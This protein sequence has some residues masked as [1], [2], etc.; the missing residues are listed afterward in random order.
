MAQPKTL[1]K[2]SPKLYP[3]VTIRSLVA[4][5]MLANEIDAN[6][7]KIIKQD[8]MVSWKYLLKQWMEMKV[9]GCNNGNLENASSGGIIQDHLVSWVRGF[10]HE[11]WI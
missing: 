11:H 6:N 10:C 8:N 7:L 3:T 9:D 1:K 4:D 2:D 5:T